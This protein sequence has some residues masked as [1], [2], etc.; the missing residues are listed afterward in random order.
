MSRTGASRGGPGVLGAL[1]LA[2]RPKTLPAA[3]VPVVVGTA[4]AFDHGAFS[5]LPAAAAL[6]VALLIQ[7]ATNYANDYFDFVQGADSAGRI[8]PTRAVQSGLLSPGQ[9]LAATVATFALAAAAGAYLV[10]VAGW[11][12]LWIGLASIAAGLWYTAGGRWSLGYLGL[13]DLFAFAFFGP[14][15]VATTTYVQ[16]FEW[17]PEALL[18]SLPVGFL[19]TAILVVNNFRDADTD[20]A[21]GKRTL[22]VR[23]GRGVSLAEWIAV[24]AGAF[25]V[26]PIHWGL[27]LDESAPVLLPLLAAPL[28]FAPLRKLL[29]PRRE[30][31]ASVPDGP[32]LNRAL[33]ET[34][35]LL[36]VF[37]LLYAIGIAL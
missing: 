13:G 3:V 12:M 24:V 37:G 9:M 21:S 8:G 35:R 22:A 17:L 5:P 25:L 4:V 18:A 31:P 33:A 1:L 36:L 10:A 14:V 7:I 26:P 16:A 15:A 23:F 11:A 29:R 20:R 6:A 19:I 32:E 28:A 2:S 30:G 27:G 34:A